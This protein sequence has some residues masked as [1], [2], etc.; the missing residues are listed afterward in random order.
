LGFV[1]LNI[2]INVT[3]N[4]GYLGLLTVVESI[5]VLGMFFYKRRREMGESE[6]GSSWRVDIVVL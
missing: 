3:G 6:N 2:G 5:S 4:Y 1:G